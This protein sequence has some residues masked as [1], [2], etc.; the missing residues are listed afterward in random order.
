M[1]K[2]FLVSTLF[3]L[4]SFFTGCGIATKN[5]YE[6]PAKKAD[7]VS[8]ISGVAFY[9]DRA[10]SIITWKIDDKD[11]D[12]DRTSEFIVLPGNHTVRLYVKKDFQI[13]MIGQTIKSSWQ[14]KLLD[15]TLNAKAGHTYIA[16]VEVSGDFVRAYFKDMGQDFKREC[17]PLRRFAVAYGGSSDGRRDGC[18]D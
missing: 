15:V 8:T 11:V 3:I 16:D 9:R 5:L 17:M 7:E 2:I 6:G 10:V 13:G 4:F 18:N 1:R 14:E 12:H